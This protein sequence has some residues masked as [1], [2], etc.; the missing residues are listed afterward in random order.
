MQFPLN[1]EHRPEH[2]KGFTLL[3]LLVTV[4]FMGVLL[5]MLL[6]ALDRERNAHHPPSVANTMK[7]WGLIFKMYANESQGEIWPPLEP[8]ANVWAPDL[9]LLYPKYLTDSALVV[10]PKH[11]DAARLKDAAAITLG[12]TIMNT[13][14]A[15]ELMALSFAYMGHTVTNLD[16]LKTLAKYR[17]QKDFMAPSEE[18]EVPARLS[19][20]R[21]HCVYMEAE[22]LTHGTPPPAQSTIPVLVDVSTWRTSGRNTKP[23]GAHVLY[24]D[25]HVAFVPMG[26][27]PLIP[28]ALDILCAKVTP[29]ERTQSVQPS[30]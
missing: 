3:E 1:T 23:E 21:S 4:I 16:D 26:T 27:F 5:A 7:Q 12:E 25:G 6:P 15:S 30:R 18:R 17:A 13:T 8:E 22:P 10:G 11:P 2:P 9:A 29:R 28:E 24:M 14:H 19:E 20:P